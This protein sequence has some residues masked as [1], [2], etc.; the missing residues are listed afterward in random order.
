MFQNLYTTLRPRWQLAT[1]IEEAGNK[2]AEVVKTTFDEGGGPETFM[3]AKNE[4][5]LSLN[6]TGRQNVRTPSEEHTDSE[7]QTVLLYFNELTFSLS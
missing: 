6:D 2:F 4:I 3:L 7:E 5:D 1:N